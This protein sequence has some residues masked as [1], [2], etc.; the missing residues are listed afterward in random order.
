MAFIC[1][2]FAFAPVLL[3]SAFGYPRQEAIPIGIE[4]GAGLFERCS[5]TVSMLGRVQARIEAARR[6]PLIHLDRK[7]GTLADRADADIGG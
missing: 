3:E 1:S 2:A 6:M 7:A 4:A 5:N